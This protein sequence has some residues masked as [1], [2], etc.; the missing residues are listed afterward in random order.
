MTNK[1]Y[2]EVMKPNIPGQFF[3]GDKKLAKEVNLTEKEI[4]IF[5]N[6]EFAVLYNNG[7]K[8]INGG[9]S[10]VTIYDTD[11]DEEGN[12]ILKCQAECG[13]QDMGGGHSHSSNDKWEV[14]YDRKTE[15]FL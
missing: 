9:Y 7:L 12:Q 4:K 3:D 14:I 6:F 11:E 8:N 15:K 1:E 13:E 2:K 5:N 10:K